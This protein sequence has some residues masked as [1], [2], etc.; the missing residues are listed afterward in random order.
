MACLRVLEVLSLHAKMWG[1]LRI[2]TKLINLSGHWRSIK[3]DARLGTISAGA[4][5]GVGNMY[6]ALH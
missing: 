3:E 6:F 1:W 4:I 5:P 2:S